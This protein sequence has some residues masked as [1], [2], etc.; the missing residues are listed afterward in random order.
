MK[1]GRVKSRAMLD[2]QVWQGCASPTGVGF[3]P[4]R[5]H[6]WWHDWGAALPVEAEIPGLVGPRAPPLLVV[7]VVRRRGEA[8]FYRRPNTGREKS[9]RGGGRPVAVGDVDVDRRHMSA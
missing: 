7:V 9:T 6:R 1:R 5:Y 2:F 4:F 8:R 3:L